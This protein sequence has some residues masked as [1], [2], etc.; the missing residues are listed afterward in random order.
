[1]TDRMSC[2]TMVER[3]TAYLEDDLPASERDRFERHLSICP[4]CV[5]YLAQMRVTARLSGQRLREDTLIPST[6]I[7]FWVCPVAGG[8]TLAGSDQP[9]PHATTLEPSPGRGRPPPQLTI[10]GEDAGTGPAPNGLR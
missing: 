9:G 1:M 2:Q 7:S 5:E 6:A 10:L 3:V 4:G 8:T